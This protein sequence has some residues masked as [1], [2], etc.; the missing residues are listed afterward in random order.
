[1]TPNRYWQLT[2]P[3]KLGGGTVPAGSIISIERGSHPLC[4][5][6]WWVILVEINGK[7]IKPSPMRLAS[8]RSRPPFHKLIQGKSREVTQ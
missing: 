5:R 2:S 3:I 7:T 4:N 1:M 8:L 6:V